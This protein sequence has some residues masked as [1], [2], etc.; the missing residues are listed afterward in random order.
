MDFFGVKKTIFIILIGLITNLHAINKEDLEEDAMVE[1]LSQDYASLI[2][3]SFPTYRDYSSQSLC[4]SAVSRDS[5]NKRNFYSDRTRRMNSK[6][7]DE[8]II[9]RC[10]KYVE[11]SKRSS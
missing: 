1:N 8:A 2:I 10:T 3:S 4:R 11:R 5:I 7:Y 9:Y 6:Q